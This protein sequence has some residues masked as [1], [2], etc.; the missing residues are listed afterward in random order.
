MCYQSAIRILF[1]AAVVD[2][3]NKVKDNSKSASPFLYTVCI[4]PYLF[5][6]LFP[7]ILGSVYTVCNRR[8][9][10][11]ALAVDTD[12]TVNGADNTE[13]KVPTGKG[14][15]RALSREVGAADVPVV[16]ATTGEQNTPS[17]SSTL[18]TIG[19][20]WENFW[21]RFRVSSEPVDN[22]LPM[23]STSRDGKG[24]E[25]DEEEKLN[26]E[27]IRAEVRN[28][29][30]TVSN[31]STVASTSP[32]KSTNYDK[33]VG[34]QSNQESARSDSISSLIQKSRASK[35]VP[36]SS[37]IPPSDPPPEKAPNPDTAKSGWRFGS[38]RRRF[39]GASTA[40]DSKDSLGNKGSN[41]EMSST[42]TQKNRGLINNQKINAEGAPSLLELKSLE[43][44]VSSQDIQFDSISSPFL[45]PGF[46]LNKPNPTS[47]TMPEPSNSNEAVGKS[48]TA[49]V[50]TSSRPPAPSGKM[51]MDKSFSFATKSAATSTIA[52]AA[53]PSFKA[54]Q[55]RR[56][57]PPI[58]SSSGATSVP[59]EETGLQTISDSKA[60]T[61][62]VVRSTNP[63][64][65]PNS[66]AATG[67][68]VTSIDSVV[69]N[70]PPVSRFRRKEDVY[71]ATRKNTST[72]L[73][74][75][76]QAPPSRSVLYPPANAQLTASNATP[77]TVPRPPTQTLPAAEASPAVK[78]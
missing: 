43:A 28:A 75:Q 40:E 76:S 6:V 12:S 55:Q 57:A 52:T 11:S 22:K 41:V 30:L 9:P 10:P 35:G 73:S 71:S 64:P 69:T 53:P 60:N 77:V 44:V 25:G 31:S 67:T 47:G 1:E 17:I 62:Q 39:A 61:A 68:A 27:Q 33:N 72:G 66:E 37:V 56:L 2:G 51:A 78:E 29:Y 65:A 8:S 3:C 23:E 36:V 32:L 21:L 34:V 54:S 24:E 18:S 59:T 15:D 5:P 45:I 16:G 20:L 4:D 49:N 48:T 50:A 7:Q 38:S 46:P 19:K 58:P 14:D 74:T 26:M 42:S 63:P 70:R 13:S